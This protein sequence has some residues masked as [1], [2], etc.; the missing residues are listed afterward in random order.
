MKLLGVGRDNLPAGGDVWGQGPGW[1]C[2]VYT[3]G[4]LYSCA[5]ATARVFLTSHWAG[6]AAIIVVN[7]TGTKNASFFQRGR[8]PLDHGPIDLSLAGDYE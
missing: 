4:G 8:E 5:N 3:I 6:S 7:H 1:P 2:W